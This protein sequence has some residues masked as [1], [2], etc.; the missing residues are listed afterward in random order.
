MQC[1][2]NVQCF[3]IL[4]I[5]VIGCHSYRYINPHACRYT[6]TTVSGTKAPIGRICKGQLILDEKFVDFDRDLW[7]HEVTLGGGGVSI[8][9]NLVTIHFVCLLLLKTNI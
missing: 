4:L 8:H 1:R 9:Y 3:V 6:P 2:G 7:S 5:S